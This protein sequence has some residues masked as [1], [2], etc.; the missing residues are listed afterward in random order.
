MNITPRTELI[1]PKRRYATC[2]S[3][4]QGWSEGNASQNPLIIV[5]DTGCGKTTVAT[6]HARL[7]GFD[8]ITSDGGDE[9]NT[10]HF[11]RLNSD[12]RMPTFFGE[13]RAVLIEDSSTITKACWDIVRSYGLAFPCI[14]TC[15]SELDIPYNVRKSGLMWNLENPTA[16]DLQTYGEQVVERLGLPHDFTDIAGAAGACQTW[17]GIEH[18]LKTSRP[19]SDYSS[20]LQTPIRM[21]QEQVSAILRGDYN[22]PISVHP[23]ALLT[24]AEYNGTDPS[25]L[26]TA[27]W[28]YSQSWAVEGL[29]GVASSYLATL[30]ART[31]DKPPFRKRKITGA[32]RRT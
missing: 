15:T 13:R 17:R 7:F 31:Q 8:L 2:K 22:R 5:G 30:R 4:F 29:S 9:R 24:T 20:T 21:G 32:N 28:L 23:M 6:A 19:G 16:D 18:L 3:W 26:K 12:G 27:N 1:G 11:K 10:D 14:I 25:V